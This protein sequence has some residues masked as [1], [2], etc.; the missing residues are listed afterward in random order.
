[1]YFYRITDYKQMDF[2]ATMDQLRLLA[3]GNTSQVYK[4][5]Y[6]RKQMKDRWA[7]DDP[8]FVVTQVAFLAT[9]ALMYG[10]VFVF[11]A[12][13]GV[14]GIAWLM[15]RVIVVDWLIFGAVM[16]TLGQAYAN[17]FL[18]NTGSTETVEWLFAF[19]I[20]CNAFVPRFLVLYL[21]HFCFLSVMNPNSGAY[22]VLTNALYVA[23]FGVYFYV[24]HLGYRALPFLR[25]TETFLY[26]IAVLVLL[27]VV[28][29]V[30]AALGVSMN[31][32]WWCGSS[33][34]G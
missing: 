19:D 28:S 14:G 25:G 9:A 7:R 12:G 16:A 30:S 27:F 13:F 33:H 4:T 22:V 2:Q 26:P 15:Y 34:L 20:H 5:S 6:Y 18:R 24:T 17:N 3:R 21:V 31:V 29:L 11:K 32:A 8:A 23:A 10:M 1:M